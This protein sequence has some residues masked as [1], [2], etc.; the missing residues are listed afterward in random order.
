[1]H[2]VMVP[3]PEEH[4]DEFNNGLLRLTMGSAG[5]DEVALASLMDSLEPL[6]QKLVRRVA[7]AST[8]HDRLPYRE[9]AEFLGVD[10]GSLFELVTDINDRCRRASQPVIL[11]T[12]TMVPSGVGEDT[13]AS[14]VLVIPPRVAEALRTVSDSP[15]K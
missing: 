7:Q 15:T 3:C 11:W 8:S 4:F 5:W 2:Y 9:V 6:E 10:V 1:M 14:P 13:K 12:D